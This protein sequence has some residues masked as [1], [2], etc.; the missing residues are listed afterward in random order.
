MKP[1]TLK[2]AVLATFLFP[3]GMFVTMSCEK[4]K[5][6]I[7]SAAFTFSGDTET[8]PATVQFNNTSS[9][10]F[11]TWDFGD[12]ESST[13]VD[14]THIYTQLGAYKVR[15][16]AQGTS[17]VDTMTME[18]FIG[19]ILGQISTLNCASA[20]NNEV[21]R[22][23]SSASGVSSV[24]PYTGGN[25]RTHSGQIVTST[26]VAGLTATLTAGSFADGPGNLT[27][28]ITGTPS[29]SGTASFAL[30]IGG[31]VCTLDRLVLSAMPTYPVNTVHCNPA[32]PTIVNEVLNP[33]TGRVW[34]DRNW[35]ASRV[36]QSSTDALAFGD[37]FQW[38]RRADG[39]QCRNS[40]TTTI[41]S[42]IN[43][44]ANGNFI[45]ATNAPSDWRNPQNGNLWQGVNGINNPCP[46]GFRLPTE[47]EFNAEMLS[48]VSDNASGAFTSPL[49]LSLAG[50]RLQN[51][52]SIVTGEGIYWTSTVSGTGTRF[53]GFDQ[54]GS[55]S[56]IS[57]RAIGISVR[58]IKN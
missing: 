14:P 55:A 10:L 35:G 36:A 19:P 1:I 13:E 53:F 11:Y 16:I 31:Q 46:S 58:C 42:G 51:D 17:N 7:A 52:G 3:L 22:V 33:V 32:N 18:I 44:P 9:G 15:L 20:I 57:P 30:N 47:I 43:Q 38:G 48:W 37:L 25:G 5:S 41:L 39:H 6:V 26:G 50:V 4:E 2:I 12:N 56:L 24:I 49:K 29:A 8:A 54:A 40:V 27:Y 45:L 21:L 34:M 23:G 28:Q